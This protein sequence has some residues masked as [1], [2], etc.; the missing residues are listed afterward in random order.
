MLAFETSNLSNK[1]FCYW[2]MGFFEISEEKLETKE[3]II[4]ISNKLE[5]IV[6]KEYG[7][8][9]TWLKEIIETI[10]QQGATQDKIDFFNNTIK[11]SLHNIFEHVIDN[12]Y[13]YKLDKQAVQDIHDGVN[14]HEKR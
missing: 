1:Q 4:L 7:K 10:L 9:T 13:D 11:Y 6:Y 14:N 5:M 12:T 2:L 8:F 3:Q